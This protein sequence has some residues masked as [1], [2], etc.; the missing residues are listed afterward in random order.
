MLKTSQ[1]LNKDNTTTDLL[2]LPKFDP[3]LKSHEV[4]ENAASKYAEYEEKHIKT[5]MSIYKDLEVAQR[6]LKEKWQA[7]NESR[8][9]FLQSDITGEDDEAYE[10]RVTHE[11]EVAYQKFNSLLEDNDLKEW[12]TNLLNSYSSRNLENLFPS[13]DNDLTEVSTLPALINKES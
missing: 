3:E 2:D 1:L 5:F 6:N 9:P 8:L 4:A 11:Y 12:L 13:N 10:D 7:L